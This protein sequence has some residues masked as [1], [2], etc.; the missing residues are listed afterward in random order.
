MGPLM[1]GGGAAGEEKQNAHR[2]CLARALNRLAP[3]FRRPSMVC[4]ASTSFPIFTAHSIATET[5]S[6]PFFTL[7]DCDFGN[8]PA[9]ALN[10]EKQLL[11]VSSLYRISCM[12]RL[13]QHAVW[14]LPS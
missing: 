3:S 8:L 5:S 2:S 6:V 7:S 13:I 4:H 9:M 10:L 14:L 11:F 12:A 1:G